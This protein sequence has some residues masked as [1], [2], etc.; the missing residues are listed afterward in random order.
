V[1]IPASAKNEYC[2]DDCTILALRYERAGEAASGRG[3]ERQR[4]AKAMRGDTGEARRGMS[5]KETAGV[6]K[7]AA[8]QPWPLCR[9]SPG[10]SCPESISLRQTHSGIDACAGCK[11]MGR[12]LLLL[13]FHSS[14]TTNLKSIAAV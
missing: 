1:N 13:E 12:C 10:F 8:C 11:P 7:L 5:F 2:G 9:P 4:A 3:E 14:Q 6:A